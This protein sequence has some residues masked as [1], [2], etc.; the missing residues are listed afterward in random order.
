MAIDP[1]SDDTMAGG[2]TALPSVLSGVG[3]RSV[4]TGLPAST[5]PPPVAGTGLPFNFSANQPQANNPSGLNT[6]PPTYPGVGQTLIDWL[7]QQFITGSNGQPTLKGLPG[8]PGPTSPNVNSTILPQVAAGYNK[9]PGMDYM[10]QLLGGGGVQNPWAPTMPDVLANGGT[11]KPILQMQHVADTGGTGGPGNMNMLDMLIYG[12]GTGPA[13]DPMSSLANY[14]I[15]STGSGMPIHNLAY[16]IPGS[17]NDYL[18]RFMT[19]PTYK[20]ADVTRRVA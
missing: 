13:S 10:T 4:P 1:T 20:P 15:A 7:M 9:N 17:A 16:G 18:T 5:A 6:I 3:G 14:G 19:A 2:G 12:R 8:Y 11:G